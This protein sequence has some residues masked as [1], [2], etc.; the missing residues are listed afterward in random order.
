MERTATQ[1]IIALIIV[2]SLGAVVGWAGSQNSVHHS[3][4]AVFGL[5]AFMAFAINWL[6]FIPS[7]FAQTEKYYDLTGSLT[8]LSVIGVAFVLSDSTDLRSQLAAL[9]VAVWAVRLGSFLFIR[10]SQD[11]HDD[12]FDKIKINPLRFLTAWTIQGLWVLFTAACAL[13]I[14][15]SENKFPMATIGWIGATVWL[16]G[17][18]IEVVADRQKRAFRKDPSNKGRFIDVG[19][20]SWS[21][22][23]NYFGEMVIWIGMAIMALPVLQGWQFVCLISPLFVIVLL[24]KVSGIP[25]LAKKGLE[26]WGDEQAYQDYLRNTSLLVPLPPKK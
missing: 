3:G 14:I 10:I 9:M 20:W 17:F 21:R 22:H 4:W 5:C 25:L 18:A 12:R 2:T 19:L 7:N 16:V 26:K 1:S 6:V 24:T 11:G 8:Y 15:T 13:A 23:P